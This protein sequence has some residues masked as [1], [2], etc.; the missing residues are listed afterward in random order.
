MEIF[1]KGKRGIIYK[2]G[3]VCIKKKNPRSAVD[4]LLNEAHYLMQLNKEGIGPGFI[5]YKKGSLYREFVEGV[6]I[7]E[8]LE[9]A[10]KKKIIDVLKQVLEQCRKMD[11]LGVNKTELTNPYK[12]ILIT[13]KNKAVMIDFERCK[14]SRNSQHLRTSDSSA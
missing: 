13:K 14:E 8:F 2:K 3:D 12:D 1:A 10:D 7:E 11:L 9:Q 5:K 4:T 6:R